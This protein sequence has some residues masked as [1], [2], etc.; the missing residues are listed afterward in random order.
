MVAH[1]RLAHGKAHSGALA[2]L[3][4]RKKGIKDAGF[5]LWRDPSARVFKS[6]Q[7]ARWMIGVP[8]FG[9]H[10]KRS[11]V[12]RHRVQSI[13]REINEDLLQLVSITFHYQ[14]TITQ[15]FYDR[16]VAPRGFSFH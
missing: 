3:L 9:C 4:G 2:W 10:S 1:Y 11:A 15:F 13:Y 14:R 8:G 16:Y 7:Q 6:N 12:G 5:E